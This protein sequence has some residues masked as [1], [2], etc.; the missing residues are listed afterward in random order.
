MAYPDW[1]PIIQLKRINNVTPATNLPSYPFTLE[2][3]EVCLTYN[4]NDSTSNE[5][6]ISVG[7][8]KDKPRFL[9]YFGRQGTSNSNLYPTL[10]SDHFQ[11][12]DEASSKLSYSISNI[13]T[14]LKRVALAI[15]KNN[16]SYEG[17]FITRNNIPYEKFMGNFSNLISH[18]Y[19]SCAYGIER[20][21][22]SKGSKID[23]ITLLTADQLNG[24]SIE[25]LHKQ[26]NSTAVMPDFEY[27]DSPTTDITQGKT[28]RIYKY[29]AGNL[30]DWPKI[31]HE[32]PN[33]NII[34]DNTSIAG[35]RISSYVRNNLDYPTTQN[36]ANSWRIKAYKTNRNVLIRGNI[37]IWNASNNDIILQSGHTYY[38]PIDIPDEYKVNENISPVYSTVSAS[39]YTYTGT[40]GTIQ[41]FEV[42]PLNIN[43]GYKTI[44]NIKHCYLYINNSGPSITLDKHIEN[45]IYSRISTV[46]TINYL[47]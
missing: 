17:P 36:N 47:I 2:E 30:T 23:N 27:S 35:L 13:S 21:N 43:I 8:G 38:I 11:A 45:A 33:G 29:G 7:V 9:G 44:G 1:K 41:D 4:K 34:S 22:T 20:H 18:N 24:K 6:G 3:G 37:A 19:T 32:D 42:V 14:W 10:K 26:V 16:E 28:H 15:F 39:K 46:F 12:E 5:V 25:I 31:I 40:N